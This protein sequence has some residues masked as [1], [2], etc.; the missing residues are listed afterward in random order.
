MKKITFLVL[1]LS[2]NICL[3]STLCGSN[4]LVY[5]SCSTGKKMISM[6]TSNPINENSGYLQYRYGTTNKVEFIYPTRKSHPLNLFTEYSSAFSGGVIGHINFTNGS[7][8]Y[9]V[10]NS[11]TKEFYKNGTSGHRKESGVKVVKN[12]NVLST[13]TCTGPVT[14]DPRAMKDSIFTDGGE[15]DY[16]MFTTL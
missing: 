6:C 15:Y 10:Y 8:T 11:L 5:F 12:G 13:I 7:Y 9:A 3:S 14:S 16:W 1:L 2:A 4:E